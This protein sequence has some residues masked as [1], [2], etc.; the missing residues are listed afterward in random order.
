[1]ASAIKE[2]MRPRPEEEDALEPYDANK[3]QR[4]VEYELTVECTPYG[5]N[6]RDLPQVTISLKHDPKALETLLISLF[7]SNL[8]SV[9]GNRLSHHIWE[10]R[11]LNGNKLL[12]NLSEPRDHDLDFQASVG[13]LVKPEDLEQ[14]DSM[15]FRYDEH[16]SDSVSYVFKVVKKTPL[17]PGSDAPVF[18]RVS[19]AAA[20]PSEWT[21]AER[22]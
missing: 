8:E 11:D 13:K 22:E 1:M 3:R 16:S 2:N 12:S 7:R 18:P 14:G 5:R 20:L 9:L 15:H 17:D 4:S 6:A 21:P 19:T 10:V